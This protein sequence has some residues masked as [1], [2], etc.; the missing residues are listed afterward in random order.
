[1]SERSLTLAE[2]SN[3]LGFSRKTIRDKSKSGE[4]P[5]YRVGRQWRFDPVRLQRFMDTGGTARRV[6]AGKEGEE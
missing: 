2:A 3:R 4:L 6:E 5:A 1:M